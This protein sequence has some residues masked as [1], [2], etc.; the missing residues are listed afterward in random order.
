V[1]D[2]PVHLSSFAGFVGVAL[3]RASVYGG[4]ALLLAWVLTRATRATTPSA[5]C[6]IWRLALLQLFVAFVWAKPLVE[7]PVFP[8]TPVVTWSEVPPAPEA[9]A[10]AEG[11]AVPLAQPAPLPAWDAQTLLVLGW[12]GAALAGGVLLVCGWCQ[13][14]RLE[15]ELAAVED[16]RLLART[17]YLAR[18]L[19]LPY[20]PYLGSAEGVETPTLLG[21]TRLTVALPPDLLR[22]AS[23]EDLELILGH[24]LAHIRRR[25]LLWTWLPV[26]A[27]A[28]FFFHPL[29]WLAQREYNLAQEGAC[30]ALAMECTGATL[31]E[32]GDLL[33]RVSVGLGEPTG[34]LAAAQMGESFSQIARRLKVIK[35]TS[36][37]TPTRR[38]ISALLVAGMSLVGLTPWQLGAQAAPL[39][40]REKPAGQRQATT[41]SITAGPFSVRVTGVRR[42]GN[43]YS[44]AFSG[45]GGAAFGSGG[46]RSFEAPNQQQE[47]RPSLTV[48]LEIR[49][50]DAKA[51]ALLDGVAPGARGVDNLGRA[52]T[53]SPM[54]V[55]SF[56]VQRTSGVRREVIELAVDPAASKL[57]SVDA[58]LLLQT[59]EER[60]VSF[61]AN[62]VR[63]GAVKRVGNVTVRIE[64]V[65]ST[66]R[67]YQVSVSYQMPQ[68]GGT[69]RPT[70]PF[71]SMQQLMLAS[72]NVSV[73]LHDSDGLTHRPRTSTSGGGGG[74][75]GGSFSFSGTGG[76]G[77]RT[78]RFGNGPG[79]G[80]T[81]RS[82]H[83]YTFARPVG[84]QPE[85]LEF[86]VI[87][88][89]GETRRI[90]FRLENLTVP[91]VGSGSL[92]D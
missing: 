21:L 86:R 62:E 1:I 14:R 38:T 89:T 63:A 34:R 88:R 41:G 69:Q 3:V 70:S 91:G 39:T 55:G 13:S 27:R 18:T 29:V 5:R 78:F 92:L 74:G 83:N 32:Y 8:S 85:A 82:T 12:C 7:L 72:R 87:E 75:G 59:G 37:L 48:E 50:D 60:V 4:L 33:L 28:L 71:G 56:P 20:V 76:S 65:E 17:G 40:T 79:Q 53:G 43:S 6:W 30:D 77:T 90:P 66:E 45:G 24:E 58:A 15:R 22:T 26:L 52:A 68:P 61:A 25:D 57:Q 80:D 47:F 31:H 11:Q 35:H 19:G 44:S 23:S 2:L 73:V 64:S 54:S 16:G 36:P 84:A 42:G 10:V 46:F 67:G 9:G 49:S 51:L 81:A